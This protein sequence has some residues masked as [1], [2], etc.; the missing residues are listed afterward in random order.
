MKYKQDYYGYVYEWLNVANGMKYIGSHYGAVEDYYIGSGKDFMIAYKDNPQNFIMNILEYVST[1]DKKLVLSA[2]KKW[3]DSIKNIKDNPLYYNLNNDA[4]GGFGYLNETHIVKR[5]ETLKKKHANHG[6]S[7]SE[8]LSYKQKI[9]S[10][11]D[12]IASTGFTEKEKQQ[13]AK[14]GCTLQIT[15]PSGEVRI[16]PSISSASRELGIHVRH[17]LAMCTKKVDYK[18]YKIV[19]L[20]DPVTKCYRKGSNE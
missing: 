13:H 1:D 18:G 15:L 9:Q 5:A 20:K 3:L 6:L 10:R 8:K 7:V 19:K 4:V 2:E 17:G 16:Y 12:R 11:L 14:Y